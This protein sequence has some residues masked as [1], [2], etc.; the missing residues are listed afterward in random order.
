MS[1]A[2]NNNLKKQAGGIL[3]VDTINDVKVILLGRS[4][5]S[6]R[7]GTYESFGGKAEDSD[8]TSL[9]TAIREFVE[10][11]F[12]YKV[13]TK[14][15]NEI[16][17]EIIKSK[18][19]I[20]SKELYGMSYLIN[21]SGLNFIFQFLL[22]EIPFL[23]KYN[24]DNFFDYKTYISE[25]TINNISEENKIIPQKYDGLNEIEKIELFNLSDIKNNKVSLRWF[26]NKII[27]LLA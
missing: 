20:K 4:N 5:K 21:F 26:T 18:I 19:I 23:E 15:I 7:F 13:S 9:H 14:L 8:I 11:F 17:C 24:V 22:S 10:E 1:F 6:K 27:K 25:R 12:N 3:I 2:V 16:V